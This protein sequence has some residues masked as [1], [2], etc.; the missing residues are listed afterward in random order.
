[1]FRTVGV[2]VKKSQGTLSAQFTMPFSV[3]QR[4]SEFDERNQSL[5]NIVAERRGV[6][7]RNNEQ[8]LKIR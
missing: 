1:M 5:E 4:H 3:I 8:A 7:L 6:A 2:A